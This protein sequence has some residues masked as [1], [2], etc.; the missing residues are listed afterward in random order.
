MAYEIIVKQISK[1]AKKKAPLEML[2]S[3][4]ASEP[5]EEFLTPH[6][7]LIDERSTIMHCASRPIPSEVKI[8]R[9][10][11]HLTPTQVRIE[12]RKRIGHIGYVQT[13]V[14][15]IYANPS[16]WPACSPPAVDI[17]PILDDLLFHSG[18]HL[19]TL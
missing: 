6:S 13:A 17:Q 11:Y 9:G 7:Q 18:E 8:R 16:C 15:Q 14:L 2:T 1:K 12:V 3:N 4:D 19:I 10:H 5:S